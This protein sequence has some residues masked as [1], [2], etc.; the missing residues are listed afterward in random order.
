MTNYKMITSND[1]LQ[2]GIPT[3]SSSSHTYQSSKKEN[4]YWDT[5]YN[6]LVHYILPNTYHPIKI[7]LLVTENKIV[8]ICDISGLNETGTNVS[9]TLVAMLL[10]YVMTKLF[11]LE[12]KMFSRT[13]LVTRWQDDAW[14]RV[15]I[16]GDLWRLGTTRHISAYVCHWTRSTPDLAGFQ[17]RNKGGMKT[18]RKF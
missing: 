3:K 12:A 15:F 18:D 6:I 1:G 4:I 5:N 2:K 11:L 17:T 14:V 9:L 10:L 8:K 13:K 16:P 7:I